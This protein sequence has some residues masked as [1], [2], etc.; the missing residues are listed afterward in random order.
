MFLPEVLQPP[1]EPGAGVYG[2]ERLQ[3]L[4]TAGRDQGHGLQKMGVAV[5][6]FDCRAD[7]LVPRWIGLD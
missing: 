1:L 2:H 5:L 6:E 7:S 4:W 3:G